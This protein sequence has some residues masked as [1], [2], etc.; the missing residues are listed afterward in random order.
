MSAVCVTLVPRVPV[1]TGL[2]IF[3]FELNRFFT[4]RW[5]GGAVRPV[6]PEGPRL[7]DAARGEMCFDSLYTKSAEAPP[8]V[9]LVPAVFLHPQSSRFVWGPS[10]APFCKKLFSGSALFDFKSWQLHFISLGG[11]C[12]IFW[13]P[14]K[15]GRPS[16]HGR[17]LPDRRPRAKANMNSH[18]TSGGENIQRQGRRAV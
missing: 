13:V 15:R 4:G 3:T 7:S 5:G 1:F 14:W 6:L 18:Q 9:N 16:R 17:G 10:R 8:F 2:A 12:V 11:S